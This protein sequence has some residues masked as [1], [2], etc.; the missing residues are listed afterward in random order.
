[1]PNI[2]IIRVLGGKEKVWGL[3][4]T[5]KDIMAKK[6]TNSIKSW[7]NKTNRANPKKENIQNPH[8]GKKKKRKNRKLQIFRNK[9]VTH[10]GNRVKMFANKS[11]DSKSL[12]TH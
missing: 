2:Y 1:M 7:A 12:I 6:F 9:S 8:N 11:N 5:V 4:R 3:E 10:I